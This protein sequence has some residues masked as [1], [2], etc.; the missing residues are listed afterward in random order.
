MA[1]L[2]KVRRVYIMK[3][4]LGVQYRFKIR[5]GSGYSLLFRQT[6]NIFCNVIPSCRCLWSPIWILLNHN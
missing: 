3:S 4:E 1:E 5:V 2:E 6:V